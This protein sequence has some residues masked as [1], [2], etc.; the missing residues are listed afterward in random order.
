MVDLMPAR[1][2]WKCK[3]CGH[4]VEPKNVNGVDMVLHYS[5]KPM[6]FLAM[7]HYDTGCKE[8]GCTCMK[9]EV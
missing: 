3:N 9:P 7:A 4:H 1:Y 6:G 8:K 2:G 5:E